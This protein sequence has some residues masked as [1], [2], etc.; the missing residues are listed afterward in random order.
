MKKKCISSFFRRKWWPVNRD[1]ITENQENK[2]NFCS[3]QPSPDPTVLTPVPDPAG[4]DTKPSKDELSDVSALSHVELS[5]SDVFYSA[6]EYLTPPSPSSEQQTKKRKSKKKLIAPFY[7]YQDNSVDSPSP[8]PDTV[9][10][11]PQP[12]PSNIKSKVLTPGPD[13]R[14]PKDKLS[15]ISAHLSSSNSGSTV[16]YSAREYLTPPSCS[17]EQQTQNKKKTRIAAFFKRTWPDPVLDLSS[18]E[19]T[20]LTPVLRTSGFDSNACDVLLAVST[21][22]YLE[23]TTPNMFC[24]TT[25]LGYIL[26]DLMDPFSFLSRFECR[27]VVG[28]MLGAGSFGTVFQG[29]RK[30]DGNKVAI[31]FIPKRVR[32]RYFLIPG[33]SKPLFAEVALNLL[34][35][36]P[37]VSRHVVQML[38][39]FEEDDR[40]VII[41]EYKEKCRDLM[42]Y[43]LRYPHRLKE[44][45]ARDLMYQAVLATKHC[46]DHGVV[47]RDIKLNN[48]LIN[49][50]THKLKLIDFG[51]GDLLHERGYLSWNYRGGIRPPEIYTHFKYDAVPATVWSLGV[52]LF[53]MVNGIHPFHPAKIINDNLPFR[54]RL[55][56]ECR[57]VIIQCLKQNPADRPSLDQLL[58][59]PWFS[60]VSGAYRLV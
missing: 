21:S 58:Q 18:S 46:A 33:Y 37:P 28:Q 24:D 42:S 36:K 49:R 22:C 12:G 6:H 25:S 41:M 14:P 48:I 15:D 2:V 20:N 23:H 34:M 57:D 55:S 51:C 52:L 13:S 32:D 30:S 40:H 39:W 50:N 7:G 27:Y 35:Q 56:T 19:S 44:N 43:L 53:R 4:L 47:H 59:H 16:F 17:T 26:E 54:K 38:E 31:K 11:E 10:V 5:G 1:N 45:V 9:Q 29:K 8:Q 60:K 3:P